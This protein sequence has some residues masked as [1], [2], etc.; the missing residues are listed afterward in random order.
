MP[1]TITV[2]LGGALL[3]REGPPT[4]VRALDR[5]TD[6]ASR[7]RV[8]LVHGG[9]PQLDEALS[10]IEG[11]TEHRRGLR[12]TTRAQANVVQATLDAIGHRLACAMTERGHP[13]WHLD[14]LQNR[15]VARC[16]RLEDGTGL[17]RV[18]TPVRFDAPDAGP[19]DPIPVVTPVGTDG[20]GPLNVNADE[21]AACV[22]AT[23]GSEVLVLA[24]SVPGVRDHQGSPIPALTPAQAAALVDDGTAAGGMQPKLAAANQALS[25]GVGAVHVTDLTP[26]TLVDV[27]DQP[28]GPGTRIA[29]RTEVPA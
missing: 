8:V 14:S 22:A 21:A 29:T 2:K 26:N 11:P 27:L 25:D 20:S 23:T 13:A 1:P 19:S 10:R 17:G 5:L 28:A 12:V 18:G 15:L 3:E 9:G 7:T 24:T 16:K 4:L 6:R